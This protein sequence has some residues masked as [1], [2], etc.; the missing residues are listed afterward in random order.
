MISN[1]TNYNQFRDN[2]AIITY[3]KYLISNSTL[4]RF[5]LIGIILGMLM[6]EIAFA[7]FDLDKAGKAITEPIKEFIDSYWPVGVLALGTGGAVVAQ[8]DLR[9]K[10]LGFGAGSLLAGLVMGGVKMGLGI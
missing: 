3:K 5:Y 10:A 9:A 7:A 6:P 2:R 8:G 4:Y 1:R